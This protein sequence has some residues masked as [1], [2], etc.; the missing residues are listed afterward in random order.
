MRLYDLAG[1][2][3]GAADTSLQGTLEED[4]DRGESSRLRQFRNLGVDRV[5]LLE[6]GAREHRKGR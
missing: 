4:R 3:D 5:G 6:T 1:D 2:T